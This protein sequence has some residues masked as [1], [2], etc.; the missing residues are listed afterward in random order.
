MQ[1]KE[2]APAIF[3]SHENINHNK[4]FMK[5]GKSDELESIEKDKGEFSTVSIEQDI[6][7]LENV[8]VVANHGEHFVFEFDESEEQLAQLKSKSK[9]PTD[10]KHVAKSQFKPKQPSQVKNYAKPL[11]PAEKRASRASK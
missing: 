7:N 11:P 5:I 10:N 2:Q 9:E 4:F 1:T 8:K 6:A 3:S